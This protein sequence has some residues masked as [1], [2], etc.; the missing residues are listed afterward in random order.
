[1][2]ADDREQAVARVLG[3]QFTARVEGWVYGEVDNVLELVGDDE[4]RLI[5]VVGDRLREGER[6]LEEVL[7]VGSPLCRRRLR[8]EH[9]LRQLR[10]EPCGERDDG[11]VVGRLVGLG[12]AAPNGW[13][14]E[15]GHGFVAVRDP[16]ARHALPVR[17]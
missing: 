11:P 8:L 10:V 14:K 9:A 5:E 6:A 17:R 15:P 3:R 16:D 2:R 1:M 7:V 13:R 4:Q 12:H